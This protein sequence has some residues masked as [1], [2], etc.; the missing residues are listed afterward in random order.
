MGDSFSADDLEE[1]LIDFAVRVILMTANR[2]AAMI[3]ENQQLCRIL[4]ASIKTAKKN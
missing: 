4:N 3:D 2:L 1:R